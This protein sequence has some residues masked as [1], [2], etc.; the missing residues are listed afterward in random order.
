MFSQK[1]S[2]VHVIETLST[3]DGSTLESESIQLFHQCILEYERTLLL[4]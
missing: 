1:S 3:F 4:K 2:V